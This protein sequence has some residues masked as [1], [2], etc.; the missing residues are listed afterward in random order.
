MACEDIKCQYTVNS[1]SKLYFVDM[2]S[3]TQRN[4]KQNRQAWQFQ[5]LSE[6]K[7]NWAVDSEIKVTILYQTFLTLQ[8]PEVINMELL[9][10][11]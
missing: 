10:L 4:Q 6:K 7:K 1:L 3:G 9:P 11:I 2:E 5:K 8:L